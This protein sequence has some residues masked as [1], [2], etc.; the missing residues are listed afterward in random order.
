MSLESRGMVFWTWGDC[1][2][3]PRVTLFGIQIDGVLD[4]G[5]VLDRG[6]SW[7]HASS[8]LVKCQINIWHQYF[9]D[10]LEN[11][12]YGKIRLCGYYL[13]KN[14]LNDSTLAAAAWN[15]VTLLFHSLGTL[16][17][18]VFCDAHNRALGS[19]SCCSGPTRPALMC[20]LDLFV[21][22]RGS[23]SGLRIT[24]LLIILYA[25]VNCACVLLSSKEV[26]S[27]EIKALL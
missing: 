21:F 3:G 7:C 26:Q 25:I 27:R 12:N 23:C 5:G 6:E 24:I 20:R 15:W 19:W 4:T 22:L 13:L 14:L 9:R 8:V 10:K 2:Q 17:K 16:K 1:V 18:N 11:C